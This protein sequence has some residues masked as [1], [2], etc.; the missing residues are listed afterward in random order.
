MPSSATPAAVRNPKL[1]SSSTWHSKSNESALRQISRRR[2]W[3]AFITG[4]HAFFGG[5]LRKW[6][7]HGPEWPSWPSLALGVS[8]LSLFALATL[9]SLHH[10]G[11]TD[12][13]GE[14]AAEQVPS[15]DRL[16]STPSPREESLTAA[17]PRS[18]SDPVT[19][20]PVNPSTVSPASSLARRPRAL[21]S[22]DELTVELS[23]PSESDYVEYLVPG[24][25]NRPVIMRLPNTIRMKY[26]QA[27]EEHFIRNVSH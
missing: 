14:I 10:F 15:S 16:P 19:E 13:N 18:S 22:T 9:F 2:Y 8:G 7:V 4:N 5:G 20:L 21:Y 24:P 1:R 6:W 27:S 23:N 25:G 17:A 3:R 12:P 26:G 11:G